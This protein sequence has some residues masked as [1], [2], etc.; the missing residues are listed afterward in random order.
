MR[1]RNPRWF[2]IL[3]FFFAMPTLAQAPLTVPNLSIHIGQAN[4]TPADLSASLQIML[5]LTVLVWR[6]PSS[7]CSPALHARSSC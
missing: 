5:V 2:A 1:N 7:C 6:R 3:L 4:Q